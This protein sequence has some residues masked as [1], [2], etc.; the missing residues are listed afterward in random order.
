MIRLSL[1]YPPAARALLGALLEKS[2]GEKGTKGYKPL[3]LSVS[4]KN[5][6]QS[7]QEQYTFKQTNNL[8]TIRKSLNSITAYKLPVSKTILSKAKNWNIR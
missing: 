1:Q 5:S 4:S 6:R 7:K 8:N 2:E 3:K